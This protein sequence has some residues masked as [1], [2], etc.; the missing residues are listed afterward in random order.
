MPALMLQAIAGYD[1]QD[2]VSQEVPVD[3]Y[4][5]QLNGDISGLRL[6]IP[7]HFFPDATDPEVEHA[8]Q[9][10]IAV[11]AGLGAQIEE[12]DLPDLEGSWEIAQAI[13]NGEANAWHEPYLAAQADDYGPQVRK[14]LERGTSMPAM[15]Y[16]KAQLAKAQLKRD[17]QQAC[18]DIDALLTPGALIPAPPLGARSVMINGQDV[19]LLRAV[20]SA[21]SPFNLTGQ[22]ALTL[23]C[24]R[25]QSGFPLAL[26]VVGKPFDEAMILRVGHAYEV[27]TPWHTQHPPVE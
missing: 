15:D 2:S 20:V 21:T 3:D 22:P 9:A 24:G 12:I 10:A 7:T 5:T 4:V 6:G 18:S 19:K 25:S 11:L 26:Q 14:F 27:N 1:P 23:P 13:I 17:V 8:F 16:V